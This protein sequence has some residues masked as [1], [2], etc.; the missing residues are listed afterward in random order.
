MP[1]YKDGTLAKDGDVV[2]GIPYNTLGKEVVG[3]I[4]NINPGEETCNCLVVFPKILGDT[5]E[6]LFSGQTVSAFRT[7]EGKSLLFTL[8]SDYGE[9]RAF[10]K[11]L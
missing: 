4:M 8:I 2:K 3:I 9:V 7:R 10:E 5:G 11:I 6:V 1:H